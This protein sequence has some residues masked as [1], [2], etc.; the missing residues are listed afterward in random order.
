MRQKLFMLCSAILAA[1]GFSISY[2]IFGRLPEAVCGVFCGLALNR[3]VF[4][5]VGSIIAEP[6]QEEKKDAL[7]KKKVTAKLKKRRKER[8]RQWERDQKRRR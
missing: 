7:S 3:F 4:D 1:L 5:M 8:R 2:S 6:I